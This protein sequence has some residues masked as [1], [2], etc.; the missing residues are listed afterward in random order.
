MCQKENQGLEGYTEFGRNAADMT[1]CFPV[2][3]I[4]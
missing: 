3:S 1:Q 4:V 2:P